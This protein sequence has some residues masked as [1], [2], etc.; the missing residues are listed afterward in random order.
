MEKYIPFI[1]P[2]LST[3]KQ[4]ILL[5]SEPQYT[6]VLQQILHISYEKKSILSAVSKF[7][8][9]ICFLLH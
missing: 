4:T 5:L 7:W 9:S 2:F 6:P 8:L 1:F 3:A